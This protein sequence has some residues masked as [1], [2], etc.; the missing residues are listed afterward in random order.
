MGG[1][2]R[3]VSVYIVNYHKHL[4]SMGNGADI[5]IQIVYKYLQQ[6]NYFRYT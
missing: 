2:K 1:S 6:Q 5:N 4:L 3:V